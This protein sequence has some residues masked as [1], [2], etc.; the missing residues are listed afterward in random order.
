MRNIRIADPRDRAP[1]RVDAPSGPRDRRREVIATL[2]M[3]LLIP[4]LVFAFNPAAASTKA[5]PDDAATAGRTS[6]SLV[7]AAA[8]ETA[9]KPVST[10]VASTPKASTPRV[11]VKAATATPKPRTVTRTKASA[12]TAGTPSP[13][14]GGGYILI[15]RSALMARP[16]SG[17]SWATL[18]NWADKAAG[19]PSLSDQNDQDDIVALAKSIVYARTGNAQY[20]TEAIAMLKA[21]RGTEA[22][23]T[24]AEARNVAPL[25]LAADFLDWHDAA[26]NAWLGGLRPD[27]IS[28]HTR[29]PNNWGTHAGASRL[30][31]DLFL[32]DGTDLVRAAAVFHGW[33]GDRTAYAGFKYGEM[34]W[35]ADKAAPVGINP[36]GAKVGGMNV[37]GILPD[38][39]RRGG[40]ATSVGADG[41]SYTWEA[42]QGAL[43]QAELLHRAGYASYSW[44]DQALRR[45]VV[46]MYAL[47]HGATGDDDWQP[48]LV[49]A[50][51]GTSFAEKAS[52]HPG[53]AFGFADWLWG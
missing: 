50:R 1:Q 14:V 15:A 28:I 46:R 20:R 36:V 42:M 35:Q 27:L 33:T 19:T 6:R 13:S 34:S 21:A 51:Y 26:W 53:K 38:D 41:V 30:A 12:A 10:K 45:A 17:S 2:P 11:V 40:A 3:L 16:T 5:T 47:G 37:D 22:R 32:R 31:V 18:K 7:T 24:L 9:R 52:T 8:N 49:N 4:A 23:G 29:R 48:S 25:A 39:M 43:L 44:G